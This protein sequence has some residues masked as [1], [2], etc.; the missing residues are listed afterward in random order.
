MSGIIQIVHY[1]Y[2]CGYIP[3]NMPSQPCIIILTN[4][5]YTHTTPPP[6]TAPQEITAR[7]SAE[8]TSLESLWLQRDD[9]DKILIRLP[10]RVFLTLR[11][12]T[13]YLFWISQ[14]GFV[15]LNG[16]TERKFQGYNLHSL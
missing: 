9:P 8:Q 15:T 10:L 5:T 4:L 7:C 16:A 14:L 3:H 6:T 12:G 2:Y 13:S 1:Y 11:S